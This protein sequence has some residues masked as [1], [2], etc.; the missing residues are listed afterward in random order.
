M[1]KFF[2]SLFGGGREPERILDDDL[3]ATQAQ[4]LEQTREALAE[5]R[6]SIR[7]AGS[8]LPP[9]ASSHMRQIDDVLRLLLDYVAEHGAST[10]QRVLLHAIASDYLPTSLRVYRALPPET[11]TDSS[12][13]TEK[14][15]EQLDILYATALDLDHQVRTGAIAE[16]STHGRFLRDRFDVDGVRIHPGTKESR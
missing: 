15:L 8:L 4:E 1:A 7:R 14:L 12:A 2:G 10:E 3:P 9:L 6:S 16:L 11:Q 13:E 5:L